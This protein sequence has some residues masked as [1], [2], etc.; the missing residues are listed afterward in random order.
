VNVTAA[1][2]VA[3]KVTELREPTDVV[4]IN[5]YKYIYDINVMNPNARALHVP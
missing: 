5:I 3:L 4:H 1:A 2:L